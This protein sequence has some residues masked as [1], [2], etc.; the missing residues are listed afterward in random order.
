MSRFA[1]LSV[2]FALCIPRICRAG[3]GEP[4]VMVKDAKYGYIDHEGNIL[5]QPQFIWADDFW[6]GL[7][8][9]YVCGRYV[10][11]DASGTLH[12]LR[13]ALEGHLE[14]RKEGDKFGFVDASGQFKIPA[15]FDEALS[16]SEGLAAVSI[17]GKWGF[18]DT[19]GKIVIKPKFDAAFYFREGVGVARSN[20]LRPGWV[21]IDRSGNV[22]ANFDY[23]DLIAEGRVP[24][25]RGEKRGFLDLRGKRAIPFVYDGVNSFSGGLAA[26]EKGEKWGYVDRDGKMVIPPKFDY[27]GPFG[28]GLAP[29]KIGKKSGFIE[30]S[31]NFAFTLS[32]D[33]AP[34]FLTGDEESDLFIAP[35]DISRFW[36]EDGNFGYVNTAGRVIWGPADSG[37]DHPPL[38]GWS[39]E[40]K[41]ASCT[42]FSESVKKTVANFPER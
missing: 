34:G 32:F 16:F 3:S 10:S 14:P 2:L 18:I 13:F 19:A 38:L 33:Y 17:G 40:E 15:T 5:I 35:A 11:I 20:E 28:S 39:E 26:V 37:P 12:P 9:V 30:K 42:G 21:L 4:L 6:H 27:A 31:G 25:A 7:G 22:I 29:A 36:T 8:T 24:V 41:T 1:L 23:V